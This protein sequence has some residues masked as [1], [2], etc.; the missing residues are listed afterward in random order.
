M[1]RTFGLL[2]ILAVTC[3]ID[4]CW[5]ASPNTT[6]NWLTNYED[7]VN[8]SRSQSKPL[9][10]FFTGTGWCPACSKLEQE[11]FDTAAFADA[12][13]D[14]FI[15]L[16]L[17]FP[18]DKS[19][20]SPQT[21]AQNKQLMKR[22]DIRSF[23]S[24]VLLESSHQ[25]QIGITGYRPGGPRQYAAHLNKIVADYGMYNQK[26]QNVGSQQLSGAELKQLYEKA[27]EL[28]LDNDAQQIILTGINSDQKEYF[29]L[30]RYRTMADEGMIHSEEAAALRQ[31]LLA[32][33]PNN[34]HKFH[35]EIAII[36]FEAYS[37]EKENY[38]PEH[39]VAPLVDYV[40][41]FGKQDKENLWRLDMIISQVYLD[42]NK[43]AQA[44]NFAQSSYESAPA[45][46]RPEIAMAIKHI[47]AQTQGRQ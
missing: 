20:I 7:A 43:L 45:S 34:E 10:L 35:F 38:T 30:E 11:V 36:D 19:N 17:D 14:K 5:S 21:M 28:N 26:M 37:E 1:K 33:D 39:A 23:P 41:K 40:E 32:S 3:I 44:L 24:V 2:F 46:V 8:K 6:I 31:Q 16:K 12:A 27:K 25:Q 15:F 29:L 47:Q 18:Q 22:F 4:S 9:L 13:G 42:K